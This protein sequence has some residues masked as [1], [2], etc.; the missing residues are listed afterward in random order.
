MVTRA[1][2][3]VSVSM[4]ARVSVSWATKPNKDQWA[5]ERD[6]QSGGG[7]PR[8]GGAK[9]SGPR[10]DCGQHRPGTRRSR[11]ESGLITQGGSGKDRFE[12]QNAESLR[13]NQE[14]REG[15]PGGKGEAITEQ[16]LTSPQFVRQKQRYCGLKVTNGISVRNRGTNLPRLELRDEND[17]PRTIL[18]KRF[19]SR[20]APPGQ[21]RG[22]ALSTD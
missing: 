17:P 10:S 9:S 16:L 22:P 4:G 15:S 1:G 19:T 18:L 14:A 7:A 12:P 21:T 13:S 2:Q 8:T 11:V 3:A 20:P 6:Q 5:E